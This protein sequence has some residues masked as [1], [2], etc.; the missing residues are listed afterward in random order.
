MRCVERE[1]N[2]KRLIPILI[3]KFTGFVDHQVGKKFALVKHL[4]AVAPEVVL[5][6]PTPVEKVGIVVNAPHEMTKG[7]VKAL[8]I[9]NCLFGV[10][11]MP[12]SDVCRG[13]SCLLQFL[14][15]GDLSGWHSHGIETDIAI[16]TTVLRRTPC[17]QSHS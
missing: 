17:H 10:A 6:G 16:Q 8:A 15:N 12:L 7:V 1:I 14:C 11:K 5:V 4:L 9:G 3:H 2:E 13:I